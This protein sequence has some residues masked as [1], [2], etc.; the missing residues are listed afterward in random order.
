MA[1]Y[2][3]VMREFEDYPK[4]KDAY[5]RAFDRMLKVRKESGKEERKDGTWKD[6]VSVFD[7]WVER[8]KHETKGQMT[9]EDFNNDGS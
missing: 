4:Y 8:W 9:I 2:H 5:I 6:G 7:W 1:T 3:Q